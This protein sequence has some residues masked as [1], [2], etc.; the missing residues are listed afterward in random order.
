MTLVALDLIKCAPKSSDLKP[1]F[2]SPITVAAN[3]RGYFTQILITWY[4]DPLVKFVLTD[5][6]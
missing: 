6:S 4:R 1:Y 3:S 5:F 2:V